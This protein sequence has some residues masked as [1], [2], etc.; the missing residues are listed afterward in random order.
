MGSGKAADG[1]LN[2]IRKAEID[3]YKYI[4]NSPFFI[5]SFKSLY[6]RDLDDESIKKLAVTGSILAPDIFLFKNKSLNEYKQLS[7]SKIKEVVFSNE[8]CCLDIQCINLLHNI[9]QIQILAPKHFLFLNSF[10]DTA[11]C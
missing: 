4:T 8:M 11:A 2:K 9:N 1:R 10:T 5:K 7:I 6:F 3:I